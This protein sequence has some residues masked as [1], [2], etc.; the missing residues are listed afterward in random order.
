MKIVLSEIW[1]KILEFFEVKEVK[2]EPPE[3]SEEPQEIGEEKSPTEL[4]PVTPT[5]PKP[6]TPIGEQ[7]KADRIEKPPAEPP[8][9]EPPSEEDYPCTVDFIVKDTAERVERVAGASVT[10][11]GQTKT[12]DVEGQCTISGRAKIMKSYPITA[13]KA[14]YRTTEDSISFAFAPRSGVLGATKILYME[15]L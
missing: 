5:E 9:V 8:F 2:P 6:V 1:E 13:S 12:T 3:V 4:E 7:G 15:R 10:F 14:G 11:L